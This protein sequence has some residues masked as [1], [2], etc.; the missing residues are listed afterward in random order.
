[1]VRSYNNSE[2]KVEEL[3]LNDDK[4]SDNIKDKSFKEDKNTKNGK[5]TE[6]KKSSD[7]DLKNGSHDNSKKEK[8]LTT[9]TAPKVSKQNKKVKESPAEK[10]ELAKLVDDKVSF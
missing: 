9:T 5:A 1:M 6:E 7:G 3:L 4:P 10:E 8:S 2:K